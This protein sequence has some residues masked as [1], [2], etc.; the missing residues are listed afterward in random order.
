MAETYEET[1]RAISDA[2]VEAQGPLRV[3]NAIKW[4]EPVREAV[5]EIEAKAG[6]QFDPRAVAAFL[7]LEHAA[8][9]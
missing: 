6:T 1:V 7:G 3:L 9:V 2:I 8:L 5:A 4:D